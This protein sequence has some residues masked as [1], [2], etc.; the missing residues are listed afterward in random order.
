MPIA[1][2]IVEA[3][4]YLPCKARLKKGLFISLMRSFNSLSLTPFESLLIEYDGELY[5]T[6]IPPDSKSIAT[7]APFLLPINLAALFCALISKCVYKSAPLKGL[8]IE[9][10]F[11]NCP[12][13]FIS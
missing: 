10:G 13:A 9:S 8:S 4:G 5:K 11:T 12:L 2:L 3:G 1:G 6:F 7:T